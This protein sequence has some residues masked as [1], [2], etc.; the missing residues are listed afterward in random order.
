[1]PTPTIKSLVPT[2]P[3]GDKDNI[4]ALKTFDPANPHYA[5]SPLEYVVLDPCRVP[6]LK[7]PPVQPVPLGR[8]WSKWIVGISGTSNP[9]VKLVGK[10][11]NHKRFV[12]YDR[13]NFRELSSSKPIEK[14][15][16]LTSDP[17]VFGLPAQ[18]VLYAEEYN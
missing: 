2:L 12:Y 10:K 16:G 17:K 1:M 7:P 13:E 18:I 3:M 6:W 11:A 15:P 8:K 9:V 5:A 4:Q 14:P